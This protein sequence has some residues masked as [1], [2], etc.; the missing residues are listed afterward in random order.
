MSVWIPEDAL[1]AG[2]YVIGWFWEDTCSRQ[3]LYK[4]TAET[5]TVFD[6]REDCR[7]I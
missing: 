3:K 6:R 2:T 7:G 4:F 5:L 1:P